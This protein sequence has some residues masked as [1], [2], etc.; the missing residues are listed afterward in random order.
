MTKI[1]NNNN[2]N[3]MSTSAYLISSSIVLDGLINFW[4]LDSESN[5]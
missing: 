4:H 5:S 2:N 1:N 3:D